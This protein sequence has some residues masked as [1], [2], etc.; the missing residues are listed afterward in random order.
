MIWTVQQHVTHSHLTLT[1]TSRDGEQGFPGEVSVTVIY[2]LFESNKLIIKM[3]AEPKD[4]PTPINLASHT[5]WNLKGHA[6]GDILSHKV[7]LLASKITPVDSDLIPTGLISAVSGTP[8]DFLEPQAVGSRIG[9]VE[10]GYDINYVLDGGKPHLTKAAIVSDEE[11]GRM[12]ELWTNQVGLQF[13]TGNMIGDTVG[14]NGV[15]Y[16]KHG[17]LCLE[18]QGFP[19]SVNHRKFPS[20]VVQPGH[21]YEH[22]MVYRFTAS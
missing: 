20:Q 10:G 15:M 1:Y 18:T 8:Y 19:D 6:N 4:K 17:G 9:E 13:Y 11:S 14:K 22:V 3:V 16:Q 7:Q 2:Q 5:Y 21:R 12:M